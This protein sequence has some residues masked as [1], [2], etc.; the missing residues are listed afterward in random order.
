MA[1]ENAHQ[2]VPQPADTIS[3]LEF[4][5]KEYHAPIKARTYTGNLRANLQACYDYAASLGSVTVWHP[6]GLYTTDLSA[7]A[8]RIASGQI[9]LAG[10][11]EATI[12]ST[13]SSLANADYGCMILFANSLK[14]GIRDMTIER[15]PAFANGLGDIIGLSSGTHVELSGV[16]LGNTKGIQWKYANSASSATDFITGPGGTSTIFNN[17]D[18]IEFFLDGQSGSSL[19][20]PLVPF[21]AYF[22]VNKSGNTFQVSLTPGGAAINLTT[23]G[24]GTWGFHKYSCTWEASDPTND[25]LQITGHPFQVGHR[26]IFSNT[27]NLNTV[28][29]M[30]VFVTA[31]VTYWVVAVPD[32]DHIQISASPGG[33]VLDVTTAAGHSLKPQITLMYS[34]LV[35][36][37]NLYC[38]LDRIITPV[39]VT[40]PRIIPGEVGAG[41]Y[42]GINVGRVSGCVF[43]AN[44]T[45]HGDFTVNNNVYE[46]FPLPS[47][48]A[49]VRIAGGHV[50]FRDNYTEIG[51]GPSQ[52]SIG[53]LIEAQA[54]VCF[55]SIYGTGSGDLGS[56]GIAHHGNIDCSG[57]VLGNLIANYDY[58]GAVLI[59]FTGDNESDLLWIGNRV[60]NCARSSFPS[61]ALQTGTTQQH[62]LFAERDIGYRFGSTIVQQ[63]RQTANNPTSLELGGLGN[64][65]SIKANTAHTINAVTVAG[66]SGTTNVVG[67]VYVLI[68]ESAFTTLG[69]GGFVTQSG[70]N[71]TLAS[72]EVVVCVADGSG[73]LRVISS[74]G[75]T[76]AGIPAALASFAGNVADQSLFS[77]APTAT[78][79]RVDL[80]LLVN[81][82]ATAGTLALQLKYNDGV[83]ARTVDLAGA[84]DVTAGGPG[85]KSISVE[86]YVASGTPTLNATFTGLTGSPAFTLRG[87]ISRT[88]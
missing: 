77:A 17:N 44:T 24:G 55:N 54:D 60:G 74:P 32:A 2:H 37:G 80:Y 3:V 65:W 33:P 29:N 30:P 56:I 4:I 68:A 8:L 45:Y 75:C 83:A 49:V 70:A 76:I 67:A 36:G 87:G 52:P 1:R 86:F 27:A 53:V 73:K 28:S 6:A 15:D 88:S 22:V 11:K 79:Y 62:W 7:Q 84:L 46:G 85:F 61:S 10:P 14:C 12:R 57:V 13:T 81:T 40:G 38:F 18:H 58:D 78:T 47:N 19:P 59:P 26:V 31:G 51:P 48:Q 66:V 25:T 23:N 39:C 5:R 64:V 63:A 69:T 50:K 41:E 43:G 42:Y 16:T 82:V 20:A 71:R 35:G 72:G 21:K 9:T 34:P